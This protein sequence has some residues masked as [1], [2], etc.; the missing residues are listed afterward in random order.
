M[1][2]FRWIGI[3][4]SVILVILCFLPWTYHADIDQTFTGFYSEKGLYGRPGKYLVTFGIISLLLLVSNKVWARRVLLFVAGVCVA[5]AI[6]TYILYTS[7]YN[8]YCPEK[9]PA[10][11]GILI[12]SVL[13]LAAAIFH[14]AKTDRQ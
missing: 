11:Y 8:A 6:K 14:Q 4:S 7:C 10:I 13:I 3:L 9:Q 1:K 5:Y 12:C 2:Y